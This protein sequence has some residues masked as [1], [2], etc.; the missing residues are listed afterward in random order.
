[1]SQG[2]PTAQA[3]SMS[4]DVISAEA[5]LTQIPPSATAVDRSRR[6][7]RRGWATPVL[8]GS[9]IGITCI[10]AVLAPVLAPHGPNSG[11]LSDILVPP[12]WEKGGS[13]AHLLGTDS[14]GR[15]I[16]SRAIYGA[17]ISMLVGLL[18]VVFSAAIGVVT[19]L[20]AGFYRSW[21]DRVFVTIADIQL[22]FPFLVLAVVIVAATGPGVVN[23]LI[24]LTLSGWVFFGRMVRAEVLTLRESEF[25]LAGRALGASNRRLMFS[26]VLPN[27]LPSV[28]VIATF[29]FAQLV[30]LEA[31]LS[32]LGVGLPPSI[33]TWGSMIEAGRPYLGTAWWVSAVPA[34]AL[35]VV[36]LAVNILGDWLRDRLDP[37]LRL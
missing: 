8:C 23:V 32:F 37:K 7:W 30:M 25:V 5:E 27:V 3:V 1:M 31:A 21:V 24:V 9:I 28:I 33:A 10:V 12:A 26:T 6:W 17:Q 34:A 16:F 13:S 29:T 18:G 14:I 4:A 22:A 35:I 19:G 15:D 20:V 11:A 2:S 36:L